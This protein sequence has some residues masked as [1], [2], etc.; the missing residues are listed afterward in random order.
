MKSFSIQP[1]GNQAVIKVDLSFMS[2]ESLNWMFERLQT[3]HL[4][5]K[6]DFDEEI[7]GIGAE[8][9]QGW[10]QKNREEYLRGMAD[11]DCD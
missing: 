1:V 2:I 11:A 4:I 7:T 6:A 9:K 3:E 10:W 8:I 5:R